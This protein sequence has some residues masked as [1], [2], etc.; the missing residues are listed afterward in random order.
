MSSWHSYLR[1][2]L[3]S[4]PFMTI[5]ECKSLARLS[6][7]VPGPSLLVAARLLRRVLVEASESEGGMQGEGAGRR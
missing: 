4:C 3:L 5:K 6:P 2:I 1:P 7:T